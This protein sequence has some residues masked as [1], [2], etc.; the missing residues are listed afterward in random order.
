M[1]SETNKK[2]ISKIREINKKEILQIILKTYEEQCKSH[3]TLFNNYVKKQKNNLREQYLLELKK[4]SNS[5]FEPFKEIEEVNKLL[6]KTKDNYACLSSNLNKEKNIKFINNILSIKTHNIDIINELDLIDNFD[7]KVE[8]LINYILKSKTR[9]I[10]NESLNLTD[11]FDYVKLNPLI[12]IFGFLDNEK[13]NILYSILCILNY[14][15]FMKPNSYL[16]KVDNL[17]KFKFFDLAFKKI[18]IQLPNIN[19]LFRDKIKLIHLYCNSLDNNELKKLYKKIINNALLFVNPIDK[20]KLENLKYNKG[21]LFFNF[22]LKINNKFLINCYIDDLCKNPKSRENLIVTYFINNKDFLYWKDYK[23]ELS[24]D[25]YYENIL[26]LLMQNEKFLKELNNSKVFLRYVEASNFELIK[27]HNKHKFEQEK[28][29]YIYKYKNKI[30]LPYISKLF[31][32]EMLNFE[33]FEYIL[34]E[35][36]N[37]M[38]NNLFLEKVNNN[39][40]NLYN[41]KE[42]KILYLLNFINKYNDN[43]LNFFI[44]SQYKG[45]KFEEVNLYYLIIYLLKCNQYYPLFIERNNKFYSKIKF[46]QVHYFGL[47][48]TRISYLYRLILQNPNQKEN[49]VNTVEDIKNIEKQLIIILEALSNLK[50]II[51]K[52]PNLKNLKFKSYNISLYKLLSKIIPSSK[53]SQIKYTLKNDN[54]YAKK[55]MVKNKNYKVNSNKP[56][57]KYAYELAKK[58]FWEEENIINEKMIDNFIV[59]LINNQNVFNFEI[60][61][62]LVDLNIDLKTIKCPSLILNGLIKRYKEKPHILKQIIYNK[63]NTVYDQ[64][65]EL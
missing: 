64:I 63:Y 33:E 32:D 43:M 35:Y 1:I 31:S 7:Y 46:N 62:K 51:L 20:I 52:N 21:D 6:E 37:F 18:K 26:S 34:I 22:F 61:D 10:K 24:F 19:V 30:N 55:V 5:T 49:T 8:N 17:R 57:E 23:I 47:L 53:K 48:N 50:N 27:E 4:I 13:D 11:H 54:Y 2:N 39:F 58:D 44:L 41:T 25:N 65:S 42:D 9:I 16:Q 56:E 28:N 3:E 29:F 15:N 59:T 14:T 45:F 36:S 40:N 60:F 38:K 12:M